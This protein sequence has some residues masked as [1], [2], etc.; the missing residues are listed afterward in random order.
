MATSLI[1]VYTG[2]KSEV[3]THHPYFLAGAAGFE[4]AASSLEE[5]H[6]E[7]AEL[8]AR[9]GLE[10]QKRLPC[11]VFCR[12]RHETMLAVNAD[13]SWPVL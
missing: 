9:N 6:S 5:R 7:S 1:Q 8:R 13:H 4:P 12:I 11:W 3:K 10:E 2:D